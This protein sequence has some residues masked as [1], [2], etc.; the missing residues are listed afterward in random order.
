MLE[1]P[2]YKRLKGCYTACGSGEGAGQVCTRSPEGPVVLNSPSVVLRRMRYSHGMI[3]R[4]TSSPWSSGAALVVPPPSF[5][6]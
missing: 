1:N 2:E 6:Q 5:M 3:S 4:S